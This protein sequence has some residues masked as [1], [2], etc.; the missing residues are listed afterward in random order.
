VAATYQNKTRELLEILKDKKIKEEK[1]TN[2]LRKDRRH[3]VHD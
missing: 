1:T 3:R 2:K